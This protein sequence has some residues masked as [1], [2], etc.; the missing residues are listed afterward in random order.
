MTSQQIGYT[1]VGAI[2]QDKL[3]GKPADVTGR[4]AL[5]GKLRILFGKRTP[6]PNQ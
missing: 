5:M 3:K 1:T 4:S 6:K 2:T